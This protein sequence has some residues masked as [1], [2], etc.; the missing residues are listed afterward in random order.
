MTRNLNYFSKDTLIL[1]NH[2]DTFETKFMY[3]II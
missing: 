1:T 2:A 3:K